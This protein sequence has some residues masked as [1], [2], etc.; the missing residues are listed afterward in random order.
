MA[1]KAFDMGDYVEVKDRIK[2]FHDMYPK[3]RIETEVVELGDT[4]VT[5]K[6]MLFDSLEAENPIATG[7][8]WLAVPGKTPY[9]NGSEIE[10]AETSA[11]GRALAFLGIGIDKA[12]ASKEEVENKAQVAGPQVKTVDPNA[13]TAAQKKRIRSLAEAVALSI[14]A[15]SS[16]WE[17]ILLDD[18][19]VKKGDPLTKEMAGEIIRDLETR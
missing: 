2:P 12:I 15:D 8:S 3:G 9:T 10:N 7:Y 17:N 16:Q 18:Y 14:A 11:V 13:A 5:M 19:G 6:A 4:R 1:G